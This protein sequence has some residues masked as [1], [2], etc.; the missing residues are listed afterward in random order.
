M[1]DIAFP[2]SAASL[3][4]SS[5]LQNLCDLLII[6][7]ALK[8]VIRETQGRLKKKEL[9]NKRIGGKIQDRAVQIAFN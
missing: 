3:A 7:G 9:I 5:C 4:A 1:V 8:Q 6:R 2:F